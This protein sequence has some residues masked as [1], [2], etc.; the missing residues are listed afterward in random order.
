MWRVFDIGSEFWIYLAIGFLAQIVDGALGM[1]YGT[2][3]TSILLA[4]GLPPVLVSASVHT[5]QFFT[6][7]ISAASH[8]YFKNIDK[9]LF[10][11][12]ALAGCVG[13]VLG[14]I[15]LTKIESDAIRLWITLYLAVLGIGIIWK[16]FK[17]RKAAPLQTYTRK[18]YVSCLGFIG[19][20]LDAIG[21]G[22][23]GPIVT[24]NLIARDESP[25]MVVGTVNAAEFFV[26]T[27]ITIAFI[28]M[29]GFQFH[30]IV[31]GLLVG[32]VM[33]APLGAYFV[34]IVPA[35]YLLLLVGLLITGISVYQAITLLIS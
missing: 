33:A 1:A 25:R 23:W 9:K 11:F 13:G 7:G 18:I 15:T 20:L 24:S 10:V 3:S 6:T 12:L 26:K 4:S 28:T 32:G 16:Y 29:I 22:G 14:A 31:L 27:A 17:P 19:A 34:R 21:G 35:R 2:L 5:A 30:Q 8:A